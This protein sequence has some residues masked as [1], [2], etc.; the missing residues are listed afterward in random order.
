M[1][2]TIRFRLT[3]WYVAVLAA[4]LVGV[5]VYQKNR[6]EKEK[7][8]QALSDV[9]G[10]YRLQNLM[11]TGQTSQVWEV[12]EQASGRHFAMKMLLPEK[13][14]EAEHRTERDKL[15]VAMAASLAEEEGRKTAAASLPEWPEPELRQRF[16]RSLLLPQVRGNGRSVDASL[17]RSLVGMRVTTAGRHQRIGATC[18]AGCCLMLPATMAR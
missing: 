4:I 16:V 10:G 8:V 11:M 9:V 15:A 13:A 3:L 5:V 1:R 12:V 7:V 2:S 17:A 6:G 18:F 14:E